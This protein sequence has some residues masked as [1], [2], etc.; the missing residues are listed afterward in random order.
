MV[1]HRLLDL[2]LLAVCLCL[3]PSRYLPSDPNA[4]LA[5]AESISFQPNIGSPQATDLG[6]L[7]RTDVIAFLEKCLAR[8]QADVEGYTCILEKHERLDGKLRDP[9]V[10]RCAFREKPFSVLMHWIEGKDQAET[11]L[12]VQG[13]ND[14]KV[15]IRPALAI[16]QKGLQLVGKYYVERPP[17]DR[18]VRGSSR[19]SMKE[20]G[21][22]RGLQRIYRAWKAAQ[23]RGTLHVEYLGLQRIPEADNRLCHVVRRYCDPPEEEGLTDVTVAIDAETWL[24]VG[25]V[26]RAG[27][28]LIGSYY[29]RDIELNPSFP[30]N[31]FKPEILKP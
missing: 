11:T 18:Q 5:A 24:L 9:E 21:L 2:A 16:Q 27:D 22:A 23:E 19:Y 10:I 28:G 29:F 6:E 4:S 3:A 15:L 20:F 31:Q 12:F 1:R 30:H 17:D 25:S 13:D 8:Y 26:L 7:A 14:N